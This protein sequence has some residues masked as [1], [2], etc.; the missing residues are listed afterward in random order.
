MSGTTNRPEW[1]PEGAGEE[2][3]TYVMPGGAT[4]GV[5][6]SPHLQLVKKKQLPIEDYVDGILNHNI[7]V[8]S[9]AITL[10]ESNAQNY[11]AM[12]QEVLQRILPYSGK[13]IRIGISG[14]PGAGKSTSIEALGVYLCKQGLKVAVLAIDPSSTLT[15]G[16]ILGDKTRMELLSRE[17]NAYIRPSP[18]AGTLGGVARKTRETI[19]AC[20]AAGFDVVLIETIGVGQSEITVRS[21]VDFFLLILIPGSGDELQGIK[22]G[23]VEISDMIAINKADG[24]NIPFAN[25][26]K[27]A[28]QQ[29]VG[30]LHPA[31]D[32]WKTIV[33]TFS[34]LQNKGISDIWTDINNFVDLTKQ[35]GIFEKRRNSQVLYWVKS[36]IEEELTSRFYN[37]PQ[38]TEIKPQI[39]KDVLSGKMTPT[40]A[41]AHLLSTYFGK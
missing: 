17:K 1:V 37:N 3:T 18:S 32:G 15:K 29:A 39:D 4:A 30:M 27:S 40:N 31:T 23:V 36:M 16:S 21:M 22:K 13:S 38:I 25:L 26:T 19:L 12:S 5:Q 24:D 7:T 6:E 2:F 11:I 10:I 20:E 34:A 33:K 9:K 41:V 28:Y 14:P 35:N 8:L